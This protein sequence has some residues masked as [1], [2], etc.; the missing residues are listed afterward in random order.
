MQERASLIVDLERRGKQQETVQARV[1]DERDGQG[2]V[3]VR[4]REKDPEEE[5]VAKENNKQTVQA[6]GVEGGYPV[7]E[8]DG[9]VRTGQPERDTAPWRTQ[10]AGSNRS[11]SLLQVVGPEPEWIFAAEAKD[12]QGRMWKRAA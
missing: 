12:G 2:R 8:P 11:G 4:E 3:R 7:F 10:L 9:T 6:R 5:R 1:A